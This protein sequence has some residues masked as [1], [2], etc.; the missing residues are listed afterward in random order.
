VQIV[1]A[2]I[3][4]HGLKIAHRDLQP[5]NVLLDYAKG[6]K[7]VDFGL[8]KQMKTARTFTVLGT[9]EYMAPEIHLQEGHSTEVDWWSLGV[10]VYELYHGHPPWQRQWRISA[11]QDST[12]FS[13]QE[14]K[15]LADIRQDPSKWLVGDS[16]ARSLVE[17]QLLVKN[18]AHRGGWGCAVCAAELLNA[19]FFKGV[20]WGRLHVS[21]NTVSALGKKVLCTR[22]GCYPTTSK[23]KH[24]KAQLIHQIDLSAP[25][26]DDWGTE[27]PI[28][29]EPFKALEDFAQQ[30]P[31][32]LAAV[33]EDLR[34]EEIVPVSPDF[35]H[36]LEPQR[37][38]TSIVLSQFLESG[39]EVPESSPP[40]NRRECG[41]R[42]SLSLRECAC[43]VT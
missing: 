29:G 37:A 16:P 43:S 2:L 31:T 22:C 9:P 28:L 21:R 26:A 20:G 11:Q 5:G 15:L 24:T 23:A 30:N 10:I 4:L 14:V 8:A 7:L 3:H 40:Q 36:F 42:G 19:P 39:M 33:W 13:P 17:E 32:Q 38:S 18:P 34:E 12:G 35:G 1:S 25:S 6:V 27:A 41:S